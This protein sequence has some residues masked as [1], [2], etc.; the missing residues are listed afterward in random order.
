LRQESKSQFKIK[1]VQFC[2][3]SKKNHFPFIFADSFDYQ[4]SK[5]KITIDNLEF[6][7]A[8]IEDLFDYGR[9]ISEFIE[10]TK[11]GRSIE[12]ASENSCER[13]VNKDV[14]VYGI[15]IKSYQY[16]ASAKAVY[17]RNGDL[18]FFKT[19]FYKK[20]VGQ[21][22]FFEFLHEGDTKWIYAKSLTW[23]YP[24]QNFFLEDGYLI[25]SD[26]KAE[27][28]RCCIL[29]TDSM[30]IQKIEKM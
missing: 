12:S 2:F 29:N 30:E 7:F 1:G 10:I 5:N 24:S 26:N 25:H 6:H 8:S 3:E 23:N 21:E 19:A 18:L 27:E 14:D 15:K 11:M 17:I 28:F 16:I 13:F 4:Q 22:L 9:R 20:I